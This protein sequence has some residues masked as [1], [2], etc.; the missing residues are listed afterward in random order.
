MITSLRISMCLCLCV[1]VQGRSHGVCVDVGQFH[2]G[3]SLPCFHSSAPIFSSHTRLIM[4]AALLR[5]H[6][7][8][9]LFI[10]LLSWAISN[11]NEPRGD[12][13]IWAENTRDHDFGKMSPKSRAF[14]DMEQSVYH[15]QQGKGVQMGGV[16]DI[17]PFSAPGGATR[18][19]KHHHQ[20]H[21]HH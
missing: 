16:S 11:R 1:C 5:I 7:L 19:G 3:E 10:V 4:N 14:L 21:Q 2:I 17:S 9:V 13:S 8:L 20:H 18:L 15:S 12:G 6:Q